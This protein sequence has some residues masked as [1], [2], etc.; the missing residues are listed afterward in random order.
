MFSSR[1]L[2]QSCKSA[3]EATD[4]SLTNGG[5]SASSG[6]PVWNNTKIDSNDKSSTIE[7]AGHLEEVTIQVT[8]EGLKLNKRGGPLGAHHGQ[9]GSGG[10]S[11]SKGMAVAGGGVEWTCRFSSEYPKVVLHPLDTLKFSVGGE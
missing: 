6:L 5:R 1:E 3:H 10:D 2:V 7:K 8:L 4:Y 9:G 11:G